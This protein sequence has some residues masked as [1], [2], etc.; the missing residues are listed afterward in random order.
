MTRSRFAS[1][2]LPVFA[3]LALS[4]A[5]LTQEILG[6]EF[7]VNSYTT[8]FQTYPS[9]AADADG[10]FVVAWSSSGQDGSSFGIF[11]RRFS[12]A[13]A[14]LATEFQVNS[15][16]TS[17]Q[18]FPSVAADADGDFVVAWRSSGQDGSFDGIFARRFSSAGAPLATE[19]Q[20]HSYTTS[21]QAF[22]SVAADA[23][24]DFVV[25]WHSY[26]QDGSS[27]GVFAQRLP[28]SA[29][30]DIDGNGATAPLTDG[31]LVLRYLFGFT[32]PTLVAGAVYLGGCTRCNAP[33][34]EA[35]IAGLV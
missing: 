28:A 26:T 5:G 2:S 16:T 8:S 15:Y 9:V 25:A 3:A 12:S 1:S 31:L 30:L 21:F 18:A 35:Y 11:A 4:S 10:D 23:D 32:G 7:Q 20:V 27:N 22:P 13:G 14:P 33:A 29:I 34:I 6:A 17:F 19:F 24:G